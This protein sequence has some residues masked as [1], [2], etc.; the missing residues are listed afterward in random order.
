EAPAPAPDEPEFVRVRADVLLVG[1][2]AA[3]AVDL[4]GAL[5]DRQAQG[6]LETPP[7]F[8]DFS[9]TLDRLC[10]ADATE[11]ALSPS[12][13]P[14]PRIT[15]R[16]RS[17]L[18]VTTPTRPEVA[19]AL[20]QIHSALLVLLGRAGEALAELDT[21]EKLA[22]VRNAGEEPA[23]RRAQLTALAAAEKRFDEL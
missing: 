11:R 1:G 19:I 13:E 16:A 10:Q 17:L 6:E 12:E 8:A 18:P 20:H 4:L 23:S 21:I 14:L 2:E 3:K 5:A 15:S 22:N 9:L 7:Q